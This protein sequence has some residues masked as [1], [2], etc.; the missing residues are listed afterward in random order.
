M[1]R[2]LGL[3]TTEQA[4]R[5]GAVGQVVS[6]EILRASSSFAEH[7]EGVRLPQA[8]PPK[9]SGEEETSLAETAPLLASAI[10]N[11]EIRLDYE[12]LIERFRAFDQLRAEF[13]GVTQRF[14]AVVDELEDL[15]KD[16]AELQGHLELSEAVGAELRAAL[17]ELEPK[18]E[19]LVSEK[20]ALEAAGE[21]ARDM[22]AKTEAAKQKEQEEHQ[23]TRD[24][25]KQRE[26][27]LAEARA[28]INA[29]QDEISAG[30]RELDRLSS[31]LAEREVAYE[32]VA[33]ALRSSEEQGR[34]LKT[35][36]DES[37]FQTA[38]L[39]RTVSE[40]EPMAERLKSQIATLQAA[41]EAER[42]AK[43]K[44]AIDRVEG[45]E[46]LRAE[47]RATAAKL[48]AATQRAE[49]QE[50]MLNSARNNYREKL[51]ELRAVERSVI[52]L[53]MQ[54]ANMTR[55]AETAEAEKSALYARVSDL[56]TAE[57]SFDLRYEEVSKALTEKETALL[58]ARDQ[59]TFES[60]RL[61]EAQRMA[62]LERARYE[63]DMVE[64]A[65]LLDK[66][67]VDRTVL[68]GAL[69]S[70]RRRHI[71]RGTEAEEVSETTLEIAQETVTE[72][73]EEESNMGSSSLLVDEAESGAVILEFER[74]PANV[75]LETL[76]ASEESP[77]TKSPSAPI[78]S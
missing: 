20:V 37:T 45:L 50:K 22:I 54:L 74:A 46:V 69:L 19:T 25:V 60:S 51:E 53:T 68:E 49:T 13:L 52:D 77:N 63:A 36:L 58:L 12:G 6:D 3:R 4:V 35:L 8:S 47:L 56:E 26:G 10:R 61:E 57:R 7:A 23:A 43:E 40:L 32:Q 24:I 11:E 39:S 15:K 64:M 55:R 48:E 71:Q 70:N 9:F 21:R 2:F 59:I 33:S 44:A 42:E 73:I 28:E 66:E 29:L 78:A 72:L 67:R 31:T 18:Y 65:R 27:A 1:R 75:T 76:V 17:T 30:R 62:R 41:V 16:K 5:S 38:R 14:V 34:M